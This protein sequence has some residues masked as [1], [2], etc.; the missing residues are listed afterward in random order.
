MIIVA[1]SRD[2]PLSTVCRWSLAIEYKSSPKIE[3]SIQVAPVV[4]RVGGESEKSS[5]E[6]KIFIVRES[7]DRIAMQVP[8]QIQICG[9]WDF[10]RAHT[11]AR[12]SIPFLVIRGSTLNPI[13]AIEPLERK[14]RDRQTYALK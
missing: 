10:G 5:A 13:G 3:G 12:Y 14:K 11:L 6:P 1:D 7:S 9:Q 4:K 8:G 2:D